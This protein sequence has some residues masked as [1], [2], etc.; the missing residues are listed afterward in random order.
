MEGIV[1][2]QAVGRS[3]VMN[4]KQERRLNNMRNAEGYMVS[5]GGKD[6]IFSS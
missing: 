3:S 6:E 4:M 5:Y 2:V 1:S